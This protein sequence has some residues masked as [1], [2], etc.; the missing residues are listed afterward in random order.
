M[1]GGFILFGLILWLALNNLSDLK[2]LVLLPALLI[3]IYSII[4]GYLLLRAK[5]IGIYLSVVNQFLQLFY[6]QMNGLYYQYFLLYGVYLY[7]GDMKLG[8][9]TTFGANFIIRFGGKVDTTYFALNLFSV[10]S[11]IMLNKYKLL[12]NRSGGFS[13]SLGE[14]TDSASC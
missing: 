8:I 5:R 12:T 2:N 1:V 6:I 14:T 4:A 3:P 10:V 9:T 7:M 13:S 11:I